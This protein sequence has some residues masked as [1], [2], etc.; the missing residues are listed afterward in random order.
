MNS[1]SKEIKYVELDASELE[2]I[3]A[4]NG[5]NGITEADKNKFFKLYVPLS[6]KVKKLVGRKTKSDEIQET[7]KKLLANMKTLVDI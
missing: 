4:A 5:G 2:S 6:R 7:F 1:T 3:S